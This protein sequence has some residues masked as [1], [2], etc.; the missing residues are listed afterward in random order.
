M[1]RSISRTLE[2]SYNGILAPF[3]N[4][5]IFQTIYLLPR[6]IDFCI[7]QIAHGLGNQGDVEKYQQSSEN[8][9]NLFK[10]DQTSYLY[11]GSNTGFVGF[12]QPVRNIFLRDFSANGLIRSSSEIPESDLGLPESFEM[13][14]H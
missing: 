9:H 1:T 13:F 5:L 10:Y 12:F 2:Y 4:H 8:W 7:S 6:A 3:V 11:N 14:Q